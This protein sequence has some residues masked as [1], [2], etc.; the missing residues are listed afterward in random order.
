MAIS[1]RIAGNSSILRGGIIS[2]SRCCPC[3]ESIA[4]RKEHVCRI[5]R[6]RLLLKQSSRWVNWHTQ[7]VLSACSSS[8]RHLTW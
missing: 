7:I 2:S 6:H 3:R 8:E 4:G 1:W 5:W